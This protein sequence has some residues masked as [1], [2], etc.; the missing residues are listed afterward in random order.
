MTLAE[1][2]MR[3]PS[4][5]TSCHGFLISRRRSASKLCASIVYVSSA[6][7]APPTMFDRRTAADAIPSL[8]TPFSPSRTA[9]VTCSI[10][11]PAGPARSRILSSLYRDDR[12]P[13]LPTYTI[14]SKMFLENIIRR[15]E[16]EEFEKGLMSHQLARLASVKNEVM[17]ELDDDGEEVVEADEEEG[18]KRSTRLGPETVLDRAVMEHNLLSCSK[19][20]PRRL[21]AASIKLHWLTRHLLLPSADS[22]CEQ[23]YVNISFSGLGALLDLAPVGAESMARKMIEQE[24]LRGWIE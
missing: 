12:T 5:T 19:V 17:V 3:P 2:S 22:S 24:R 1:S 8:Q 16:V 10:L 18:T 13:A 9:S 4:V 11:A 15:S 7:G 20:R 6:L 21:P 14:L 23:L